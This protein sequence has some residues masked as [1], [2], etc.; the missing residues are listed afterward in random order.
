MNFDNPNLDKFVASMSGGQVTLHA[1][2]REVTLPN[3]WQCMQ[4]SPCHLWL[5]PCHLCVAKPS[6]SLNKCALDPGWVRLPCTAKAKPMEILW[7]SDEKPMEILRKFSEIL[8]K[9]TQ[10]LP[11]P[12]LDPG[13]VILFSFPNPLDFRSQAETS[14]RSYPLVHPLEIQWKSYGNPMEIL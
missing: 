8:W 1:I 5:L 14:S 11:K 4:S 7:K 2:S 9:P 6:Q 12:A 3:P 10:S 13:W